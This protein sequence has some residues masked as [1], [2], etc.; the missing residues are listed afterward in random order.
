MESNFELKKIT[1][2]SEE[3]KNTF[4]LGFSD[5]KDSKTITLQGSGKIKE[6]AS[7]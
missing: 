7:V 3:G 5:E 6:I 1:V 2:K 4:V